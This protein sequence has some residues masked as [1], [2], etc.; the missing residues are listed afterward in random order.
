MVNSLV[1]S[2][3]LTPWYQLLA[4][5]RRWLNRN[6]HIPGRHVAMHCHSRHWMAV[7]GSARVARS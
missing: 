6:N 7:H 3:S 5:S 1:V 4:S 2:P